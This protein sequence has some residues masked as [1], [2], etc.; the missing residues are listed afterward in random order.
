MMTPEIYELRGNVIEYIRAMP[1]RSN[2]RAGHV[3]RLKKV[4]T[5]LLAL[6]PPVKMTPREDI[7][8]EVA[9]KRVKK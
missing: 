4:T 5:Q 9:M 2:Y 3:T 8:R 1:L 7:A 6:E